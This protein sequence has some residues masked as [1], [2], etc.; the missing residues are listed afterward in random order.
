MSSPQLITAVYNA[1]AGD[2]CDWAEWKSSLDL[3]SRHGAFHIGRAILGFANR[4]PAICTHPFGGTAYVIVGAEPGNI[5]GIEPTDG[6]QLQSKVARYVGS[7]SP[8]WR[9]QYIQPA[10]ANGKTVLV[11]EVPPPKPGDPGYPL[12]TGYEPDK[13]N[14]GDSKNRAGG[15]SGTM[16]IRRGSKTERANHAE[17][18]MLM[19]RAGQRGATMLPDLDVR[20]T[21]VKLSPLV[22]PDV[23][24]EAVDFW[25]EQRRQAL[26]ARQPKRLLGTVRADYREAVDSYILQTAPQ[27]QGV[28]VATF[29]YQGFNAIA[30]NVDNASDQHLPDTQ[31]VL[32]L[33]AGFSVIDRDLLE[34]GRFPHPAEPDQ[35][36]DRQIHRVIPTFGEDNR[37]APGHQGQR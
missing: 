34:L 9:H 13:A 7:P 31:A 17:M 25:L 27:A 10:E 2:E 22:V 24:P 8:F 35:R 1:D 4:D 11:L 32:T 36:A 23:S 28:L 12:A 5:E 16:F 21:A 29:L 30:V 19:N 18:I 26:L 6:A 3:S 37:L 14:Q 15:Q 33:P 20:T